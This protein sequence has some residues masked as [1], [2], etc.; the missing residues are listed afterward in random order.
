[1]EVIE[2]P[3]FTKWVLSHMSDGEYAKFQ[4]A[5]LRNPALGDVMPGG[6]G[7]RKIRCKL[8]GRG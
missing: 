1:M 4:E 8:A 3:P 5:L 2:L 6:A 7:L